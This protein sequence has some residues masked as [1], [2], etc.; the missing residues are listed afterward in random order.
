MEVVDMCM[1]SK[2]HQGNFQKKCQHVG[3]VHRANFCVRFCLAINKL[4]NLTSST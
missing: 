1:L 4:P 2:S 3:I